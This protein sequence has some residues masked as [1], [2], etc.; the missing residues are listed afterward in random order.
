VTTFAIVGLSCELLLCTTNQS[1]LDILQHE[2][3]F[4]L[5]DGGV[6]VDVD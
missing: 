5:G 2:E 1:A 3:L 4:L 6:G